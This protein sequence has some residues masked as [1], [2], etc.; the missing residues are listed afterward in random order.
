MTSPPSCSGFGVRAVP[1]LLFLQRRR[2]KEQSSA[3]VPKKAI[4]DRTKS[5]SP[6]ALLVP[7]ENKESK[8]NRK[9]LS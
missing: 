9:E 1:T 5:I 8:I 3:G 2:V 4:V 6:A 7:N